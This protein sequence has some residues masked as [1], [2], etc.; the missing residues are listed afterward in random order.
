[1]TNQQLQHHLYPVGANQHDWDDIKRLLGLYDKFVSDRKIEKALRTG[2]AAFF[3]LCNGALFLTDAML[4]IQHTAENPLTT[5]LPYLTVMG[6]AVNVLW[7]VLASGPYALCNRNEGPQTYAIRHLQHEA[8][9]I[10]AYW[11]LEKIPLQDETPP[12]GVATAP[13]FAFM[14]IHILLGA[15]LAAIVA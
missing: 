4:V 2:A 1:M 15:I 10:Q 9:R 5:K 14:A 7:W 11:L 3:L 13:P 8:M 12:K 6:I